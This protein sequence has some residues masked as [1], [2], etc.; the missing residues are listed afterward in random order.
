MIWLILLLIVLAMLSIGVIYMVSVFSKISPLNRIEKKK[1][2][3]GVS[4]L[5][6]VILFIATSMIMS[7]MNAI[8]IFLFL[9]MF[10]IVY[11]AI[12]GILFKFVFKKKREIKPYLQ[13]VFAIIT[14]AVYLS[15]AYYLCNNV[16]E[17]KYTLHTD[18][19]IENVR[20]AMF[21]DSHLSTT[22]DGDEFAEYMEKINEESPDIVIIAGDFVDDWSKKDDMI[23][24]CAALG[25]MDAPLGVYLSFGNHDEGF[26]DS[27][28]FSA[29]D[30]ENE[31][32]KNGVHILED[33][34][35]YI[36]DLCI[37]G[38]R[39]A[40]FGDRKEISNLLKDVDDSKYIVVID[41]EPVDYAN[42]AETSADLVLSGHTHGGQFF[43]LDIIGKIF[44]INDRNYGHEKRNGTD[45]I[46]TSGIS[47]WA[48]KFK[49]GT[50]SEYVIIDVK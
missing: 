23:R 27:R 41:H 43:S 32:E 37:V 45:F 3:K 22:F 2:K 47:N 44:K 36:G 46:V 12:L 33:E 50:K 31:L 13:I 5:I 18:K 15:V 28:N 42:E 8:I 24:G 49:T 30:L 7:V 38:R 29:K 40:M 10:L 4:F 35:S 34:V 9:L 19:K 16:W 11:E 39:D 20:I 26:Y 14:T 25:K 1:V 48:L 17:T 21:A 6:I